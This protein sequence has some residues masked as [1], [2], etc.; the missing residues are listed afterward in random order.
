MDAFR[1]KAKLDLTTPLLTPESARRDDKKQASSPVA[2]A[3]SPLGQSPAD[4]GRFLWIDPQHRTPGSPLS[5]RVAGSAAGPANWLARWKAAAP[6]EAEVRAEVVRSLKDWA[7]GGASSGDTKR[8]E[9]VVD[10][11]VAGHLPESGKV[12]PVKVWA[13]VTK[14]RQELAEPMVTDL[15]DDSL[16]QASVGADGQIIIEADLLVDLWPLLRKQ[17]DPRVA[18]DATALRAHDGTVTAPPLARQHM[19][20]LLA[21]LLPPLTT[22]LCDP[23]DYHLVEAAY[24]D[25]H[26]E[27]SVRIQAGEDVSRMGIRRYVLEKLRLGQAAAIRDAMLASVDPQD[28]AQAL[29]WR[30]AFDAAER[31]IRALRGSELAVF[32]L[33]GFIVL[34]FTAYPQPQNA[35]S[36]SSTT[37]TTTPSADGR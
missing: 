28:H 5:G 7:Q 20:A 4:A 36:S 22:D 14:V 32:S 19:R 9:S 11:A 23:S 26:A 33:E 25:Y 27:V 30:D 2:Q 17:A 35:S 1:R 8:A 34:R 15:I 6:A 29:R 12:E 37:T 31:H 13:A 24:K 3:S 18:A 21:D 10:K 16:L